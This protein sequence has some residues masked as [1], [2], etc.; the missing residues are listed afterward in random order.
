[1]S[2][3]HDKDRPYK[4]LPRR[5][6]WERVR[7]VAK[8]VLLLPG[9]ECLDIKEGLAMGKATVNTEFHLVERDPETA[10]VIW[11]ECKKLGLK[12]FTI[13]KGEMCRGRA[14]WNDIEKE[15]GG[16]FLTKMAEYDLAFFDFCGE[17][18]DKVFRFLMDFGVN[19]HSDWMKFSAKNGVL[20]FTFSTVCRSN[21]FFCKHEENH[22]LHD[23][24]K[25]RNLQRFPSTRRGF[26]IPQA[27][28]VNIHLDLYKAA[29]NCDAT[30][31]ALGTK[32][33]DLLDF[34]TYKEEGRAKPMVF[35]TVDAEQLGASEEISN[36]AWYALDAMAPPK[37]QKKAVA[38]K[39]PAMVEAG[40]KAWHT[41]RLNELQAE[42]AAEKI[43]SQK[44]R[45]KR[46][47]N[48]LSM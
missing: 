28:Q 17:M 10:K 30:L 21:H 48:A 24:T 34:I 3:D 22:D 39:S 23:A 8:K 37:K 47:M 41:R 14:W 20:A 5:L 9:R 38:E 13:L 43:P 6:A 29:W 26:K 32:G 27:N 16:D 1:M 45:I 35:F 46:I 12:N 36:A 33:G 7:G 15:H 25:G 40:K 44:A 31:D 42:Y 2:F 4:S 18:T 19:G 11:R